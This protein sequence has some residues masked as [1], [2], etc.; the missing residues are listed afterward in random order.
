MNQTIEDR[1]QYIEQELSAINKELKEGLH[2][3][4]TNFLKPRSIPTRD[5]DYYQ[6]FSVKNIIKFLNKGEPY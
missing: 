4:R 2:Q 5:A 3:Y 6:I 1:M